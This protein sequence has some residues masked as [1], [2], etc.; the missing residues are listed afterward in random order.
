MVYSVFEVW[1][2]HSN[3]IQMKKLNYTPNESDKILSISITT[4]YY[5]FKNL[6]CCI[7]ADNRAYF[8][9]LWL[10]NNFNSVRQTTCLTKLKVIVIRMQKLYMLVK[11]V[12]VTHETAIQSSAHFNL[13]LLIVKHKIYIIAFADNSSFQESKL[14][15]FSL[16]KY[17]SYRA[18]KKLILSTPATHIFCN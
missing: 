16:I 12:G 10:S 13:L 2:N 9:F 1:H 11:E 3:H 7:P 18:E 4:D 6:P 8:W 14:E 5:I 15:S 17:Y